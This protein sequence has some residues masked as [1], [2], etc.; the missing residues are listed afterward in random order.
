MFA[1]ATLVRVIAPLVVAEASPLIVDKVTALG[2]SIVKVNGATIAEALVSV[3]AERSTTPSLFVL[4]VK[5]PP[6]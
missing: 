3:N 1:V 6:G 2:P 4:T 5:F